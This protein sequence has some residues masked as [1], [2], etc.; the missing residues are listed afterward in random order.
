MVTLLFC[1]SRSETS[2][3]ESTKT[4]SSYLPVRLGF[5]CSVVFSFSSA[6]SAINLCVSTSV[7]FT[8]SETLNAGAI[9]PA[10]TNMG[11]VAFEYSTGTSTFSGLT[12]KSGRPAHTITDLKLFPSSD[13]STS[14]SQS[15]LTESVCN[16][17]SLGF[18]EKL[19]SASPEIPL[20]RFLSMSL[21]SS[22]KATLNASSVVPLI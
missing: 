22:K 12:N 17:S 19:S 7:P 1:S 4:R 3:P 8:N 10:S 21:S 20:T 11:F 2:L 13:S 15:T 9:P 18:H 5:Q 14:S 16:P 6:L